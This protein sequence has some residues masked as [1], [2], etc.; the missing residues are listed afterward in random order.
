MVLLKMCTKT[1]YRSEQWILAI[2]KINYY[3]FIDNNFT[4][5]EHIYRIQAHLMSAYC[6]VAT[7]VVF[8]VKT[9]D[10]ASLHLCRYGNSTDPTGRPDL[11][12]V[13]VQQEPL[14]GVGWE[15]VPPG[16]NNAGC[17][18][19]QPVEAPGGGGSSQQLLSNILQ[20]GE[21]RG[22]LPVRKTGAAFTH[23]FRQIHVELGNLHSLCWRLQ[24]AEDGLALEVV[25]T[26]SIAV[27]IRAASRCLRFNVSM[28]SF[29]SVLLL[30]WL[31]TSLLLGF[32]HR[33]G[34]WCSLVF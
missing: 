1:T 10:K 15:A 5:T 7:L 32:R 18:W 14:S 6:N 11:H 17:H 13:L 19:I 21:L 2:K 27:L 29:C 20:L 8:G 24:V 16:P 33:N 25:F 12:R 3:Y 30:H 26:D 4:V 9:S 28:A 31:I 23:G 34:C 22:R